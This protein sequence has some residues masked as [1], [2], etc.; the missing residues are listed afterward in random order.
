MKKLTALIFH[1]DKDAFLSA[2]Q[3]L[4]VVH[5]SLEK[6]ERID[7]DIKNKQ[8]KLESCQRF[9]KVAQKEDK[10]TIAKTAREKR[11]DVFSYVL[12]YEGITEEIREIEETYEKTERELRNI[13]PW[14]DFDINAVEGLNAGGVKARFF[15]APIKKFEACRQIDMCYVE[16]S[17]PKLGIHANGPDYPIVEISR[18]KTYVYFVVFEKGDQI[19]IDCDEFFYPQTDRQ[20]LETEMADLEIL[21]KD[22]LKQREDLFSHTARIREFCNNLHTELVYL[23]V[24]QGLNSEVEGN[25]YVLNGWVPRKLTDN[26]EKFLEEKE[27][28]FD[29]SNP[30]EGENIPVLLKNNRFSRLFEPITKMFSLPHY[31]EMDLTVFFAP[32][33]TL[34]FGFCLADAGYGLIIVLICAIFWEKV[35]PDKRPFLI[36]GSIFGISTFLFGLIT[37]NLFGIELVKIEFFKKMVLLDPN[38]L[39]Y[40]SLK[41][42]IVQIFFGLFL[43]A[44]GKIRQF[45]FMAS[46]SVWGW[47]I[48]LTG[49]VPLVIA[50]LGKSA[51]PE[52]AK[53]AA[54]TGLVLILF[55]NDLKANIFVRF[56]LGLWELY[57]GLTGFLGDVLSY[58]RLF[59]LGISSSILGLV[60]NS[61]ALQA[62]DIPVIGFF[63][64][65]VLLVVLHS[66]NFALGVLSSFVH[67]LRL[68]F[69]EFYKNAGFEG[70]GKAYNPFRKIN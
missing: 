38:Q 2:L 55:F 26:V 62:K 13:L 59:A 43:K 41:I 64:T 21:K 25:V 39:F 54:L 27:V 51:S 24:S 14:G 57:G 69:V 16:I 45:G 23:A 34:F 33:F 32:F 30:Q 53:P 68:T 65:L 8:K 10:A 9:L 7:E 3:D 49:V 12:S 44:V 48:M 70:G 52:W 18:D 36:L 50:F 15:I 56:G 46:L 1:K 4:G 40:L 58:V 47:L 67:P 17:R 11:T 20:T 29:F 42:G 31:A 22:K 66:M 60:F 6:K 37:G 28:Y 5:I 61:I 19:E 63:V 35:D